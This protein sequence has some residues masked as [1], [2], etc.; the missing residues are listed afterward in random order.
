MPTGIILKSASHEVSDEQREKNL[1]AVVEAAGYEVAKDEKEEKASVVEPD[2]KNFKTEEEFE[3]AHVAWQDAQEEEKPPAKAEEDDEE[4]EV[5][6]KKKSR[7]ERAID[8]ATADLKKQNEDL[9]KR[10]EALESGG[11]KKEETPKEKLRPKRT[12]FNSDE[13]YEDALLAWGVEKATADK[14]L[15]DAQTA[16]QER[17]EENIRNYAAQVEDA[18]EEH[19]DWDEVVNQDIYI[20]KEAQLAILE[21]ENGAEVIYYLGRHPVKAEALGKLSPLSAVMEVKALS[22]RL[23]TGAP[24]RGEANGEETPK[25]KPKVPAPVK[26][27]STAGSS[28]TPTFAEIAAKPNYAGKARDLRRAMAA[29]G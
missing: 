15:K 19:D 16:D 22:L 6:P 20:G 1:Q 27:V 13:E 26:T 21:L 24:A 14:K 23:K 8:R 28:A 5:V 29:E 17:F 3:A 12:E 18:K 4:E 2:R 7:K 25:P 10:L 11:G 9:R